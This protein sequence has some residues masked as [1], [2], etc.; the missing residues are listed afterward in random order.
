MAKSP[1]E[2]AREAREV[3]ALLLKMADQIEAGDVTGGMRTM[4]DT[5]DKLGTFMGGGGTH[6]SIH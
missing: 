1:A 5:I 6:D 3:A 4:L 2:I